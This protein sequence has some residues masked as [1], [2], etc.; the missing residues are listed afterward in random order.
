MWR[1]CEA[2][3]RV[4]R[5]PRG[6]PAE[7]GEREFVEAV[8]FLAR[9][10]CPW[11]DLPKRFG[12]WSAVYMRFRRWETAGVWRGLWEQLEQGACPALL[13]VFI[14]S[15]SIPVHPHAA[16]APKKT[17]AARLWVVRGVD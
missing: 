13:Q 16:G 12:N 7:T 8:L 5:D 4:V 3:L 17:V 9:T 6:A 15:T 10:G 11:R 14:D 1:E 2:A